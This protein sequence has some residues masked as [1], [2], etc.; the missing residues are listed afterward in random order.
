[1]TSA[2]ASERLSKSPRQVAAATAIAFTRVF[3]GIMWLVEI[4]VGHNWKIGNPEWVGA[5]AGRYVTEASETA[6]ADGTWAGAAWLFNTLVIPNAAVAGYLVIALQLLLAVAFIIGFAVRPLALAAI[7]MDL[8]IF[9]LGNSRIPPFFITAHIFLLVTGAGA[10]YGVDG[11]ILRATRKATHPVLRLLRFG[12]TVPIFRRSFLAPATAVAGLVALFFFLTIPTRETTRMAYVGLDLA[13]IFGLVAL[14]FYVA[15]RIPDRLAV[16]AAGLRVFVG[17]KF[18]HEIWARTE[19][20]VNALPGFAGAE[21]QSEVFST[22][23]ANH[24]SFMG[25]FINAMILPNV[26]FWVIIFGAVQVAVGVALVVGYQTRVASIVGLVFLAAMIA[27]GMTRYAPFLF[28]LLVPVLALDAGRVL[29]LDAVRA[30]DRV[31]R[32]GLPIPQRTV[33]ALVGIAALAAIGAGIAAFSSGLVPDGYTESMAAFT[34]LFA[35]IMFGTLALAG[36]L[37]R[38]PRLDASDDQVEMPVEVP[39]V[40]LQPVG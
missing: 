23:A 31:A 10:Y 30:P 40:A 21:A 15:S 38:H 22:I 34:A 5:G 16:V 37:Q 9:M 7:V 4:T 13:A 39:E 28:G 29:S 3:I 35:A 6:I 24:W 18:L 33:P 32:F 25:S 17:F 11:A 2:G 12:L 27:L 1:M 8:S 14:G 20:G 36:W 19:P 26:E